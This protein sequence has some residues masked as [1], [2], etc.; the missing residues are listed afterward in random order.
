MSGR[1]NDSCKT[2]WRLLRFLELASKAKPL[3]TSGL[4]LRM[5]NGLQEVL[6]NI[7]EMGSKGG[8]VYLLDSAIFGHI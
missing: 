5:E 6:K 8:G 1:Q 4:Q 2:I 7:Q 3:Q